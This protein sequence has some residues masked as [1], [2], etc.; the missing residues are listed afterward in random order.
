MV[1]PESRLT[2]Q[3]HT[4]QS[5][6]E[7]QKF[8][9][10]QVRRCQQRGLEKVSSVRTK[11]H[12]MQKGIYNKVR[13]AGA[14][15]PVLALHHQVVRKARTLDCESASLEPVAGRLGEARVARRS[16]ARWLVDGDEA[17]AQACAGRASNTT[18]AWVA[19]CRVVGS[20]RGLNRNDA[21][22]GDAGR[23][24]SDGDGL[25]LGDSD[26][27]ASGTAASR[28]SA[29][30]VV[31]RGG[32]CARRKAGHWVDGNVVGQCRGRLDRVRASAAASNGRASTSRCRTSGAG[33]RS[34]WAG[35]VQGRGKVFGGSRVDGSR[36][37]GRR[38]A[39]AQSVGE[40]GVADDSSGGGTW[41]R[42]STGAG[43]SR[44]RSTCTNTSRD[45]R[46]CTGAAAVAT[47]DVS[48]WC[49]GVTS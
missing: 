4:Q 36:D 45:W 46:N 34:G 7:K 22:A 6:K 29:R 5:R 10:S 28:T 42:R 9:A 30:G 47:W 39:I 14:L 37:N 23:A 15:S 48:R 16:A 49:R 41:H 11:C 44:S 3:M 40:S 2:E 21:R 20:R 8:S 32:A 26:G 35:E 1:S 19:R 25:L 31:G 12:T 17:G 33:A 13:V 43:A 38:G 27:R 24:N 18:A